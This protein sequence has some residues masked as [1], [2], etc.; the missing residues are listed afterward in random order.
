[1]QRILH[2]FIT[3]IASLHHAPARILLLIGLILLPSAYAWINILA[4]WNPYE[5]TSQ[6]K[7][8][9]VNDDH[10]ARMQGHFINIG[11]QTIKRLHRNHKLDWQFVSDSQAQNLLREEKCYAVISIPATF[12]EKIASILSSQPQQP[13]IHFTVNEKINAIAPKLTANGASTLTSQISAAFVKQ[14]SGALF[15]TLH[16]SGF[17][18]EQ[19][20]PLLKK[21]KM[22]LFKLEQ[23]LPEMATIGDDA[24]RL[25]HLFNEL[26]R[27]HH[28]LTTLKG[29][30]GQVRQMNEQLDK[31]TSQ[32]PA[33]NDALNQ[34]AALPIMT[35]DLSTLQELTERLTSSLKAAEHAI[36]QAGTAAHSD[37][38]TMHQLTLSTNQL[39]AAARQIQSMTPTIDA[40]S[41]QWNTLMNSV[42]VDNTPVNYA[43]WPGN[44]Q[45]AAV[46]LRQ[47]LPSFSKDLNQ[48]NTLFH[49]KQ[50]NAAHI[51][52]QAATFARSDLP[53]LSLT[54]RQA[55]Q[56]IRAFD[57]K[58]D[59][60]EVIRLLLL[61]PQRES[62]FLS[63]PVRLKE[64]RLFSIPNYG[65]AMAPFYTTLSLWVGVTLLISLLPVVQLP[66]MRKHFAARTRF[67]SRLL[68]FISIGLMQALIISLGDLFLLHIY[69]VNSFLFFLTCLLCDLVFVVLIYT[70]VAL[71]GTVGKGITIILLVLQI[72]SSS[73]TF[74]VSMTSPFF[75]TIS[76][77]LPFTYAISLMRETIGGI[78]PSIAWRDILYLLVFL[79]VP[80]LI[81]FL[82]SH[83]GT[84]R[85]A[86]TS[87][88]H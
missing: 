17:A 32:L 61:N 2:D 84:L 66:F 87:G 57:A 27:A 41:L 22:D 5:N 63:H 13:V 9:V 11:N 24:I 51:V 1:M 20:L 38:Q 21:A 62:D 14:F 47:A 34:F 36:G 45:K 19:N 31:F 53:A 33:I 23:L 77:A 7:V 74:P 39:A 60:N 64:H 43:Q 69:T 81:S 83:G 26:E 67:F 6:L 72:S 44:L 79:I 28:E 46:L 55:A 86:V 35:D 68:A 29:Q 49:S 75:E 78:V 30:A 56:K 8:A 88:R 25:D 82:I 76:P 42:S 37:P 85:R 52:H 71:F 16:D 10:G 54:I 3:D 50:S 59:L 70:L 48:A 58:V 18:L 4:I 65:S 12:S 80:F 40:L 15:H 73:G